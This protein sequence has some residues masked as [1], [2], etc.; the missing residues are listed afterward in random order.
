MSNTEPIYLLLDELQNFT[1]W[2]YSQSTLKACA[3]TAESNF[4]TW[5]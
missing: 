2:L 1:G 3:V 4:S 5:D